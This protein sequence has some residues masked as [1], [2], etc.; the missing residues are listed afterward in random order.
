MDLNP[1]S[2]CNPPKGFEELVAETLKAILTDGLIRTGDKVLLAIS[3]G[4]DSVTLLFV[5]REIQKEIPFGLGLGH[6]NHQLR[7]EESSRDEQFILSLGEDLTLPVHVRR[8]DVA[9][10][11]STTGLS[12]QHAA[13]ELRYQALMEILRQEGFTKIAVAH[14][15]DDQIETFFLRII[16]GTGLKGLSSIPIKRDAIIRPFLRM[17]RSR[18]EAYRERHNL[19]FV[20]DSSN[21]KIL[22]E[23]NFLRKKVL[24]LVEELNPSYRQRCASLLG[25]IEAE[26]QIIDERV[27]AFLGRRSPVPRNGSVT[28]N[29]RRLTELD[30]EAR[31]RVIASIVAAVEPGVVPLRDHLEHICSILASPKPNLLTILPK[32]IQVVKAYGKLR[33]MKG[34]EKR[35]LSDPIVLLPGSNRIEQLALEIVVTRPRFV[36]VTFTENRKVA[37]FD[38]DKIGSLSVRSFRAGDR[39]V[40]LGLKALVK[41]KDFFI[42]SKI[43]RTDRQTVPL[44]LS[45]EDIVWVG[46]LRIDERFKITAATTRTI[47]L[48]LKS[49]KRNKDD[50]AFR[51]CGP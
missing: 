33:F 16:K 1:R 20:E 31:V 22:Y 43:P 29:A 47:K 17:T 6:V 14:N 26:N 27:A 13:R 40:P 7:G 44:V 37:L 15:L 24:P 30:K 8:V 39:F 34:E 45:G 25:D 36:P 11:S 35:G 18:I 41:I 4:I 10:Y 38:A 23:R 12:I 48:T 5:L 50:F 19:P 49:I 42:A 9:G 46:G 32:G 28:V 3:G 51:Q 2:P 21:R